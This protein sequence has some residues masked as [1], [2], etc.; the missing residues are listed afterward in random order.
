[1]IDTREIFLSSSLEDDCET[2]MIDHWSANHF[3]RNLSI[4]NS[5]GDRKQPILVH[6]CTCGGEWNYG[7]AIYD[8][9]KASCDDEKC[10]DVIILAHAHA[11]SMSSIIPQAAKWRVI[12]PN[13][14]FLIHWGE[15]EL[16]STHTS[17]Q[18]E[19]HWARRS[20]ETMLDI[21]ID[22]CRE[23]SYWEREGYDTPE[24]IR[25]FLR[26]RMDKKQEYYM[27]ARESVEMGFMDAVLGDEGFETIDQ[28]RADEEDEEE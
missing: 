3:I 18:A 1:M 7:I 5:T 15:L 17:V 25:E 13:A 16:A 9:I 28:L 6:M 20:C 24:T 10:S 11:R 23:A 19:A 8:A 12:M 4:L 22:R 27:T 2:A 26:D 21:Y 14:D